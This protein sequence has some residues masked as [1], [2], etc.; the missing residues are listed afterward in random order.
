[1][2]FPFN[3]CDLFK[4]CLI[5]IDFVYI[6]FWQLYTH[7]PRSICVQLRK[8]SDNSVKFCS[9]VES[10]KRDQNS[11]KLKKKCFQKCC[12]C[13]QLPMPC[14]TMH[15]PTGP[16]RTSFKFSR[17]IFTPQ[18]R[19]SA[20]QDWWDPALRVKDIIRNYLIIKIIVQLS[21]LKFH[22]KRSWDFCCSQQQ[23]KKSDCYLGG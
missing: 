11:Q 14:T 7:K 18:F 21:I 2:W 8:S 3:L 16:L 17:V 15:G 1:M 19:H 9:W 5:L 13:V 23:L 4:V 6:T 20:E 12:H 10:V 22:F